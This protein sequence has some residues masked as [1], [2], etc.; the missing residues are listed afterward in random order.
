MPSIIIEEES[1]TYSKRS[2][3][4]NGYWAGEFHDQGIELHCR[5]GDTR[6]AVDR[7]NADGRDRRDIISTARLSF[8]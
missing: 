2:H 3:K 5:S 1:G 6:V 7:S 4:H 8:A